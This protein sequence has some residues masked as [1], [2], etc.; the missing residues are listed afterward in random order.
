MRKK[1]PRVSIE[2]KFLTS[3]FWVGVIPMTLA[4]LIGYV[5]ARE[6]QW[7]ATQ[8]NLATAARKTAEG[9]WLALQSRL[10]MTARVAMDSDFVNYLRLPPEERE[11]AQARLL[12]RL[13]EEAAATVGLDSVFA[14][15]D[16]EGQRVLATQ[17]VEVGRLRPETW[18][19]TVTT[20]DFVDFSFLPGQERYGVV[21]ISPI[22][23]PDTNAVLGFLVETQGVEDLLGF[24]LGRASDQARMP[25]ELLSYQVVYL[26]TE[27]A[28]AVCLEEDSGQEH[29]ALRYEPVDARL[30][31]RLQRSPP[32]DYDA[33]SLW[34]YTTKGKTQPVL[35]A[36]HRLYADRNLYFVAYRP[37]SDVFANI[38]LG[39]V[40]T[41]VVS[42]MVIGFFCIVGYRIVNNTI[43]RPVSLLN[44]G[45]QI[46]RQGDLDLKLRIETG[47]EIEE[48]A[49]SFN[50]MAAALRHNITQLEASEEKYRTLITSMRDGIYQADRQ[51]RLTFIN[52]AGAE[53][54]GYGS[55]EEAMGLDL[56]E[57]FVQAADYEHL[58]EELQSN[59]FLAHTRVWVRPPHGQLICLEFSA[60]QMLDGAGQPAG[61]EGTFR[62]MTQNVRLEQEAR[63]R[64]ERISAINQI[65]NAINSSLEAGR[66][67]ESIV[68]EV[69]RL[70]HFDYAAVALMD[71]PDAHQG[72]PADAVAFET[73]QMWPEP[74]GGNPRPTWRDGEESAAAWVSREHKPLFVDDL[75]DNTSPFG[76]QFPDEI[77]SCLCVPLY[78]LGRI[79]GTLNLGARQPGGFG[80]HELEVIEQIT[81]HVAVAIRNA[82]LLENL[83]QSLEEVTRA[84]EKLHEVNEELKTLD[85][86][87]TNL[88]SNVSHELRTP[89]VAVMGYTDM[90]MNGKAGPINEVQRE[91]LG[92]SLRNIEK[93]VTLIENLLDFSRLHRGTEELAFDT[94]DLV[95]CAR[96]S[97]QI[98]QPLADGRDIQLVLKSPETKV[99]VDG[100]KGK[101]GQVFNNLLSNAVKFNQSGG[102]VSVDIRVSDNNAEVAVVDTGIGMPPEALDKIFTRFYQV[103]ASSTR[104]Y[105][106]TGIGLSI[107]QDI[108]RLHGSG[109]TVSSKPGAGSTFR[110]SLPVSPEYKAQ[111]DSGEP[112][113]PIPTETHLLVE[114]V[115][116]DRALSAQIRNLLLSEGMDVIH[117]AYPAAAVSLANK[118][119]PDCIVVD[120][121]AGPLGTVVIDEV[122][123]D[124]SIRG[125]PV[126]LLTNDDRLFERY[127]ME[128][129]GR[130]KRGFRKSTLLSGIHYALSR[131][132]AA[133]EQL[134]GKVLCVDDDVEVVQFIARCLDAEGYQT[135]QCSTGEEAID[136][137]RSGEYWLVLL[138]IAM[139]GLDGWET[140]KIIKSNAALA[141]IK[142]YI[143]TAKPIDKRT[144][145]LNEC[146]ADGYLLKPFKAD[147]LLAL[148]QSFAS[149]RPKGGPEQEGAEREPQRI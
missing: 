124:P 149:H 56:R 128:V 4:L 101:L 148:V 147:D 31:E 1:A 98:V 9:V 6:G 18:R 104:K 132:V 89:L 7:L 2:R 70:I 33:F 26:G 107:A 136:K 106:G 123:S 97:L 22:R 76:A 46:I 64:S 35:M 125:I 138:D 60:S 27:E 50:R 63:D 127:R 90:I 41:I 43:I 65:T 68:V 17:P 47:D 5:F 133:G 121:E 10:Q 85:E 116:Q 115:T 111:P 91:Y 143:V 109:I 34:R 135:D 130:V 79:I 51:G 28:V 36:Y 110:F 74:S 29:T 96:T 87:K 13:K 61:V 62:D 24:A 67:Y 142:I 8:R 16:L 58:I 73:R 12:S 105:G 72:F 95:D 45:A 54:F 100:D 129:S 84:R 88:L 52:P 11:R 82:R 146:G 83:Q 131:G 69:K 126:I 134:G 122:L 94:L 92:I 48:L 114:V 30:R 112:R 113:L 15:Y 108:M 42:G 77:H 20:T 102:K 75:R 25:S 59:H 139:P 37:L 118:Y 141:G 145:K 144:P 103:D 66:V 38:H 120:T 44:E 57:V 14:L 117:A 3:I 81:P 86:M 71:E 99:L 140:S 21:I 53:V 119:S 19:E 137:V 55:P 39:A 93:L 23:D 80:R 49:H 32:R 78:A 40:L